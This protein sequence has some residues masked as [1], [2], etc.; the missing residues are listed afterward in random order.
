MLRRLAIL[1]APLLLAACAGQPKC[2]VTLSAHG[3]PTAEA[4]QV[5]NEL[6]VRGISPD[7]AAFYVPPYVIA[8]LEIEGFIKGHADA[9]ALE[10]ANVRWEPLVLK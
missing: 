9:K 6:V 8:A 10:N 4:C 5:D 7:N 3:R 2:Y 1:T